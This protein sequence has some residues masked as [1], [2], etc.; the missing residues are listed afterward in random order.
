[1]ERRAIMKVFLSTFIT[2]TDDSNIYK[3]ATRY[4]LE[5]AKMKRNIDSYIIKDQKILMLT[6]RENH[7]FPTIFLA[8][9]SCLSPF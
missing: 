5:A 9:F 4:S 8:N 7:L 1:M 3:S 2:G 6:L